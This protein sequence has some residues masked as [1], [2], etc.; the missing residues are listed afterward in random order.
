MVMM[1]VIVMMRMMM[2]MVMVMMTVMIV[3]NGGHDY[4]VDVD[5]DDAGGVG[6]NDDGAHANDDTDC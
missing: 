3:M 6:G 4:H 1:M 5:G 2:V